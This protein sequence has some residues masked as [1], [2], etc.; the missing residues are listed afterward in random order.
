MSRPPETDLA[1][2]CQSLE[3]SERILK[4]RLTFRDEPIGGFWPATARVRAHYQTSSLAFFVQ[5]SRIFTHELPHAQSLSSCSHSLKQLAASWSGK[6]ALPLALLQFQQ[7]HTDRLMPSTAMSREDAE[8]LRLHDTMMAPRAQ[9]SSMSSTTLAPS[10]R[11]SSTLH[12][13][14]RFRRSSLR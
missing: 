3:R 5:S 10:E 13:S 12:S 4:K 9:Q 7:F 2:M 6:H 1:I 11:Y 14:H 8:R